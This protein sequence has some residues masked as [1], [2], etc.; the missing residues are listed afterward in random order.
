MNQTPAVTVTVDSK[1]VEVPYGTPVGEVLAAHTSPKPV[2]LAAIV[3][4]RCVDLDF[5]LKANAR[6]RAVN[7][8]MRE[9]VL[10]YRRTSSLILYAAV[11]ELYGLENDTDGL[12]VQAK[13]AWREGL[14]AARRRLRS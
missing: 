12:G 3:H 4:N 6:V 8:G 5:P 7:Y 2:R 13:R 14:Q 10:V 11:R 9:G 1:E